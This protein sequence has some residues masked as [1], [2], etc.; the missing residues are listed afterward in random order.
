MVGNQDACP[1][2]AQFACQG[3]FKELSPDMGI[4]SARRLAK[5]GQVILK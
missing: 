1:S 2:S 3:V 4:N 5:N